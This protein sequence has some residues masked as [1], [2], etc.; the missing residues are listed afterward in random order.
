MLTDSCTKPT[1]TLI[2]LHWSAT[3]LPYILQ[4]VSKRLLISLAPM[5]SPTESH[6]PYKAT[7]QSQMSPSSIS[8][9]VETRPMASLA[10]SLPCS[11]PL[12]R[13]APR[14]RFTGRSGLT[15][16]SALSSPTWVNARTR[17]AR[18]TC[19]G[20]SKQKL[21]PDLGWNILE[22]GERRMCVPES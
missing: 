1:R 20:P 4:L 17:D 14:S 6:A 10:A 18:T 7:A 13:R 11:M 16:T 2:M 5:C 15:A 21:F 8:S 3:A 22:K 12:P 9:A 19:P